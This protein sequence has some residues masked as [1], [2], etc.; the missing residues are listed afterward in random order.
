[1]KVKKLN[2]NVIHECDDA[3]GNPTC[4]S[5]EINHSKYGKYVWINYMGD[6][7]NVEVICDGFTNI[8]TE[9]VRCKSLTSA[10]RWVTRY[11]R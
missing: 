2:W 1:M 3:K 9:L 4:W 6:Y 11:L 5:A 10:K 7:Y 8:F